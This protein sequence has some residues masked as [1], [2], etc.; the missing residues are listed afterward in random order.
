MANIDIKPINIFLDTNIP[1]K[2]VITLSKSI[3]YHPDIKDTGNW[4][5]L[6]FFT[7]DAE[8][9][10]SYLSTLPYTEQLEFFFNKKKM[11]DI[12]LTKSSSIVDS[13]QSTD[14]KS[15][16]E[17]KQTQQINQINKD[18]EDKIK[19]RFRIK[20]KELENQE[21]TQMNKQTD[22]PLRDFEIQTIADTIDTS[23][24]NISF[25]TDDTNPSNGGF[26]IQSGNNLDKFLVNNNW[27]KTIDNFF[28]FKQQENIDQTNELRQI[29]ND[30][31]NMTKIKEIFKVN[32][33][34]KA[35]AGWFDYRDQKEVNKDV[36]E[37]DG[38]FKDSFCSSI[39]DFS[40]NYFEN[41]PGKNAQIYW[42][43]PPSITQGESYKQTIETA[44]R[45]I[46]KNHLFADITP[47]L[48]PVL[49]KIDKITVVYTDSTDSAE[50]QRILC[51]LLPE[52]RKA[53]L[54]LSNNFSSINAELNNYPEK[55]NKKLQ[56]KKEAFHKGKEPFVKQV[57][58][59]KSN[60]KKEIDE[61]QHALI[62][63]ENKEIDELY[64]NDKDNTQDD[65]LPKK[66]P[67]KITDSDRIKVSETNVIIM[68]RLVFPTKYPLIG[69]VFSSFHS[70]IT[71]KNEFH[72]KWTDFLPGFLKNKVF[73]GLSDYS[74]IK[75]DGNIY[76][77]TQ[78]IWLNDIYNHTEY[79][80][81]IEQFDD[82]NKWKF[83]QAAG[84]GEKLNKK[85]EL[86]RDTY[87]NGQY[88]LSNNDVQI[89]EETKAKKNSSKQTETDMMVLDK[90]NRIIDILVKNMRNLI[91]N[92]HNIKNT[93]YS[94]IIENA[95]KIAESLG[96][97]RTNPEY[98][99]FFKPEN[100]DKYDKILRKMKDDIES[101][102]IDEY[103]LETY[104]QYP[105]INLE[106]ERD[107]PKY[108]SVLE[109]NYG[110]YTQFVDNIKKF[111]APVLESSNSFLQN[112]IDDFL[113]NTE[114]YK[115]IFNFLMNPLNI[116][117]NPYT[118]LLTKSTIE[119]QPIIEEEQKNYYNRFNTG[120]T[121][122]PS[123]QQNQPYYEIY[124][125]LNLI[126]GE[127][128]DS[129]KSTID[130]MYQGESLGDK[131]SRLLNEAILQPWNVNG[132]RIFF[133]MN[134]VNKPSLMASLLSSSTGS[135]SSQMD[136]SNDDQDSSPQ[137][138]SPQDSSPQDSSP[139]DSSPQSS[140]Q[141]PSQGP[142]YGGKKSTRKYREM[143]MKTRRR[144]HRR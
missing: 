72:L 120:I 86:F 137:S 114:K 50:N 2:E 55:A 139:Q 107:D 53:I 25:K 43:R 17:Q 19:Q 134:K 76:T 66:Q 113:N 117:K 133:D 100:Q 14:I 27:V 79:K 10:E 135:T 110:K 103:I 80:K 58:E 89:I 138:S 37:S 74:Y 44:L 68:L 124:I 90:Y 13:V 128:N 8:Y 47:L 21:Q 102:K 130:C 91:Y 75:V 97:L 92:I 33:N 5:D 67:K 77:V 119:E 142:M 129:N 4:N 49:N 34:F 78:A 73:E 123:A 60:I 69:N 61:K 112:S 121:K 12:L 105:G 30:M 7:M 16:T 131:L 144:Y 108:K 24:T 116:K 125:Q 32:S 11:N 99:Q 88:Q 109:N 143:F 51:K 64:K 126:G 35:N 29:I 6:P 28:E 115:G 71:G 132:S 101:I 63:Q 98:S 111:R 59:L 56:E 15:Q 3:L 104:L 38:L 70:V 48:E 42:E 62:D 96:D 94:I 84:L 18:Y 41:I 106:Y 83:K 140:S 39:T 122:R 23:K 87:S 20:K 95:N 31:K 82:L 1:G 45:K 36:T 9:P 81:L 54:D 46:K 141:G 57:E 127:L 40:Q 85:R 26:Y 65:V 52:I 136:S 118:E 22:K 93:Q